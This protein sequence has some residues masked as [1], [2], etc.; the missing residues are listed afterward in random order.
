M[1]PYEDTYGGCTCYEGCNCTDFTCATNTHRQYKDG[2]FQCKTPYTELN[3]KCECVSPSMIDN[4][5]TNI[6][7]CVCSSRYYPTKYYS[8]GNE[9]Y[10]CVEGCICD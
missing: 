6:D 1:M 4:R 9:C 8:Y 7:N 3:G 5:T 2:R 10:R